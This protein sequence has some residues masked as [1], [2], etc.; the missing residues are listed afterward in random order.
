MET[1]RIMRIEL[2][3]TDLYTGPA[4]ENQFITRHPAIPPSRQATVTPPPPTPQPAS[5]RCLLTR[6]PADPP[7]AE[8]RTRAV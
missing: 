8:D 1:I 6:R 5:R 2:L 3:H 4:T 7:S